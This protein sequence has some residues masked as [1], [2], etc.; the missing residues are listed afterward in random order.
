MHAH[1]QLISYIVDMHFK[2]D[3]IISVAKVKPIICNTRSLVNF[4]ISYD[5]VCVFVHVRVYGHVYVCAHVS[6]E[7]LGI[8][9]LGG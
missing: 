9:I 3:Q 7:G 1:T 2:F 4:I 5:F 6:G 8:L